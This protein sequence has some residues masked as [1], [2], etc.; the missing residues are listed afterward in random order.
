M[1]PPAIWAAWGFISPISHNFCTACN[2]IRV[3]S[4][5]MLRSCLASDAEVSL[6]P[7]LAQPDDKVLAAV[8]REAIHSKPHGH[9]FG[10]A[11]FRAKDMWK[12]GG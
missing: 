10:K 8:I 5:G 9:S 6:R 2:R 3:T 4:D 7:A 1:R 12:I 11:G